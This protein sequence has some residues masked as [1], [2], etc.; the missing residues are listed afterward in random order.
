MPKRILEG[1]VVSTKMDKTVTV[2]VERRFLHP[3]YKKYVKHSTKFTAHDEGNL[4]QDNE[5][6]QIQE[7]AP[8]SKRKTWQVITG[9][10]GKANKSFFEG[11][12]V[13]TASKPAAK[14]SET[15][16][17]ASTKTEAKKTAPKKE[18]AKKATP[19]KQTA[20][21]AD[22]KKSTAKK[23]TTKKSAAKKTTSKKDK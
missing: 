17:A 22:E 5:R 23:T 2:L 7:C 6:V 4:C 21:K 8:L 20:K 11:G 16:K 1:N 18:T 3:V 15:K 19:K 10:A 13:K 12:K 14:K 9:E